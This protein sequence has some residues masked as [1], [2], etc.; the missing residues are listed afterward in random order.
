M[1]PERRSETGAAF[2]LGSS[3]QT[4]AG[5]WVRIVDESTTRGYECVKGDDGVWRYNRRSCRGR[6]TGSSNDDPRNL[7]PAT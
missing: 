2:L 5:Q 6:V 1:T 3:Y 4:K 7:I